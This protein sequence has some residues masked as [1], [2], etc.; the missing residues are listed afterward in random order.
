LIKDAS[1]G[2]AFKRLGTP[3]PL[4]NKRIDFFLQDQ[5]AMNNTGHPSIDT[6]R[7]R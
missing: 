3:M 6:Q 4:I 7:L 2:A 5:E 1:R